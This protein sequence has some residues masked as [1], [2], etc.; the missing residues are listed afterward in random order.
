MDDVI[1]WKSSISSVQNLVN[2]LI[3]SLAHY[4]LHIQPTKCVL[5]CISGTRTTPLMTDGNPLYPQKDSDVLFVMNLP[6]G[7]EATE[8]RVLEYLVD[9]ARKKYFGIL[10]LLQSKAALKSRIKLLNTVVFGVFRWVVGALFPTPQ[11]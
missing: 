5:V 9:R 1:T 10:H 11:L 2:Q 3:P 7:P 6:V 8:M 4:G